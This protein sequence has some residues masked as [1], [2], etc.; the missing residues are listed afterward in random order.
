LRK[1]NPHGKTEGKKRTGFSSPP[2]QRPE[3]L[4]LLSARQTSNVSGDHPASIREKVGG[5]DL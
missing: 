1:K 3:R 5:A 2:E 4:Y